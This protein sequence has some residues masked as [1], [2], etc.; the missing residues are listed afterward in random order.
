MSPAEAA[1][2]YYKGCLMVSG[3]LDEIED[4]I[5]TLTLEPT[6]V[7]GFFAH[8]DATADFRFCCSKALR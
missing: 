3:G 2:E 7:P 4:V 6:D 1:E 8:S 5:A